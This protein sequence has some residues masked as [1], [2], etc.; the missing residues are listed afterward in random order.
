MFSDNPSYFSLSASVNQSSTVSEDPLAYIPV[1]NRGFAAFFKKKPNKMGSTTSSNST[2]I[3]SLIHHESNKSISSIDES[4]PMLVH[5]TNG[6]TGSPKKSFRNL[7]RSVSANAE[8]ERTLQI[9]KGDPRPADVAPPSPYLPHRSHS[10]SDHDRRNRPTHRRILKSASELLSNDMIFYGLN[11]EDCANT[12]IIGGSGRNNC[13]DN[14]EDD[15]DNDSA[16]VF[17]GIDDARY[18][19]LSSSH[20]VSGASGIRRHSIGTFI[21]KEQDVIT[22]KHGGIIQTEGFIKE[23]D[24]MAPP[25]PVDQIDGDN[26]SHNKTN[27]KCK[28]HRSTSR[29]GES[30]YFTFHCMKIS[31]TI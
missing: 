1:V 29:K 11:G 7:F 23:P 4:Q 6:I 9:L 14:D 8:N 5:A 22:T 25:I 12:Q 21:G 17:L 13:N 3:N 24:T 28:K 2:T 30:N 15:E 26:K 19:N 16:E 31:N 20:P 10:H 18:Y 27:R